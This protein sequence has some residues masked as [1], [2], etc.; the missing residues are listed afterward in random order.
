[1]PPVIERRPQ[2]GQPGIICTN[3]NVTPLPYFGLVQETIFLSLNTLVGQH[4][5]LAQSGC[6]VYEQCRFDRQSD[7]PHY[8]RIVFG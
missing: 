3:T 8:R 1:M 7:Y 5:M 4:G 6:L 2:F